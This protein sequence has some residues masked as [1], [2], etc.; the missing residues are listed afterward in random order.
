MGYRYLFFDLDNTLWDFD[1]NAKYALQVLFEKY[2]LSSSYPDFDTY[3]RLYSENNARLWQLYGAG[4]ITKEALNEAR[5]AYPLRAFDASLLPIA[6]LMQEDYLPLLARQ[7]R[8]KPYC[9]EVLDKLKTRRYKMY[10]ISNGFV[11]IQQLKLQRSGLLP[12][13]ERCYFSEH[14]GAH[15]P[16]KV[17]FDYAIKSSNALKKQSL[18]IGD[19]F[20]AD[21]VGA[22]NAGIDQVYFNP[23][24]SPEPLPFTPKFH[25]KNLRALLKIL[26]ES[27]NR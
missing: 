5:F 15:K 1:A 9:I 19:N 10:I 27:F 26:D 22:K 18:V 24:P 11:E 17:F 2:K 25:I 16:A 14:I 6:P 23:N 13:F 3:Y 4:K 8:L 21:I 20:E 12:Y 7:T